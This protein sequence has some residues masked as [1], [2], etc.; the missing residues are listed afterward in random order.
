MAGGLLWFSSRRPPDLAAAVSRVSSSSSS[1]C[2]G[3]LPVCAVPNTLKLVKDAVIFIEGAQLTPQVFMDLGIMKTVSHG[4]W[5]RF[6]IVYGALVDQPHAE[7]SNNK[8]HVFKLRL[9]D[10]LIS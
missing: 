9:D 4:F 7:H 2:L 3:H 1:F 8:L 5:R 10:I 6:R